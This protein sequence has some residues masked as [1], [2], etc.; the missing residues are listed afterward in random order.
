MVVYFILFFFF[1]LY[2]AAILIVV[3]LTLLERDGV[4]LVFAV[5]NA[6]FEVS[7]GG[8]PKIEHF[9]QIAKSTQITHIYHIY[10]T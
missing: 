2:S 8:P 10:N 4:T 5:S 9:A 1:V 7:I 3:D 6:P